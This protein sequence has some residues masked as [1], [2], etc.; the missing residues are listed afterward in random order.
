MLSETLFSDPLLAL[1]DNVECSGTET[2]SRDGALGLAIIAPPDHLLGGQ[3]RGGAA[4]AH[5]EP[6]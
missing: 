6:Y 4:S 2:H 1:R 5:V 3:G